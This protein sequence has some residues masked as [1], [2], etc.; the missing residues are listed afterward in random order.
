MSDPNHQAPGQSP[1]PGWHPDPHGSGLRWWD[2]A[3]WTEHVHPADGP[4]A[5]SAPTGRRLPPTRTLVLLGVL[6]V[7]IVIG[8][9]VLVGGGDDSSSSETPESVA[10]ALTAP[11]PD[12]PTADELSK[13]DAMAKE[14]AHTAQIAIETFA[15]ENGGKYLAATPAALMA[16]EPTLQSSDFELKNTGADNYTIVVA[17]ESGDVFAVERNA[18]GDLIYEC[19]P[20]GQGGCPPSGDWG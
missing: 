12:A 6:A 14:R 10:P 1:A 2:G 3:A 8:I 7:V 17:S 19:N 20:P 15:T 9:V 16:I 11:P 13:A 5:R 4:E 18:A